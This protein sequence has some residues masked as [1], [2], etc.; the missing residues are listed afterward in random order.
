MQIKQRGQDTEHKKHVNSEERE[1]LDTAKKLSLKV[2]YKDVPVITNIMYI[3]K[4]NV[5]H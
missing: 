1:F 4:N 2:D 5:I 3:E